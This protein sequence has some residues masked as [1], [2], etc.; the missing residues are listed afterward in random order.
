MGGGT[1]AGMSRAVSLRT[2]R[3][4]LKNGHQDQQPTTMRKTKYLNRPPTLPLLSRPRRLVLSRAT[5]RISFPPTTSSSRSPAW[6]RLPLRLRAPNPPGG[7]GRCRCNCSAAPAVR[8][9]DRI[10]F[11]GEAASV[12][13][14][15]R[16]RRRGWCCSCCC[17]GRMLLLELVSVPRCV[18]V[19]VASLSLSFSFWST[20]MSSAHSTSLSSG[21]G[22]GE[23]GRAGDGVV[24]MAP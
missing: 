18:C 20:S 14:E 12:M 23:D 8:A 21:I 11:I 13:L 16:L 6:T 1:A 10:A 22:R 15:R 7:G 2:P 19:G 3:L 17:L 9:G 24:I 4:G 5:F